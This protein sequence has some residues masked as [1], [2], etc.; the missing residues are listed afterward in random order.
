M[1]KL[2]AIFILAIIALAGVFLWRDGASGVADGK[3]AFS[4][5]AASKSQTPVKGIFRTAQ[6]NDQ[7]ST[8]PQVDESALRYFA[9]KGD[10]V[11]LQAEIKRLKA[12]YPN[13]TPPD[14]PLAPTEVRDEKLDELWGL[15]AEGRYAELRK[16]IAARKVEDTAWEAP[17]DLLQMLDQAERRQRLVNASDNKQ[18][19]MVVSLAAE[20]PELLVC[21]EVDVLWRLSE[22]F[23]QLGKTDRARDGYIYVLDNCT[24]PEERLAT[25]QKALANLPYTEAQE[26][27]AHQ[28]TGTDGKEEFASQ[29]ADIARHLLAMAAEDPEI[30]LDPRYLSAVASLAE[31][32]KLASDAEMLGWYY[33][34]RNDMKS[35]ENW[36]LQAQEK[37]D[38]PT[39]AQGLALILSSQS[40]YEQAENVMYPWRDE[41]PEAAALYFSTVTNL[42]AS[43]PPVKMPAIIPQNVMTRIAAATIAA[44]NVDS[45]QQL[46]WYARSVGQYASAMQW[47]QTALA[48]NQSNEPAAY[49][50]ALSH[51]LNDDQAALASLKNSWAAHSP[52]IAE[53]GTESAQHGNQATVRT[54][55]QKNAAR[56]A[57]PAAA[58]RAAAANSPGKSTANLRNCQKTVTGP[59][60][61]GGNAVALGWCLMERNRA[62]EAVQSF[63]S[64]LATGTAADRSE[65]AY[66]QALAYLRL[67]LVDQA[68]AASIKAPL[69]KQRQKELRIAILSDRAVAAYQ[70]G[71]FRETL[72][73]L[74]QR[75]QLAAP[76]KDLMALQAASYL[77]LNR[78]NDSR[79]VYEALAAS[80]YREGIRGLAAIREMMG[81]N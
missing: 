31:Q 22:A 15:Y 62:M 44:K 38:S 74:E 32:Q 37:T 71:N 48:W 10:T 56:P 72:L 4:D 50:L 60:P 9:S 34:R 52:R 51:L 24:V 7:P 41:T 3:F 68:A 29:A 57:Q 30:K 61:T 66:G 17:A 46:G 49:G 36:L 59:L 35:A 39:I 67:G 5:R 26:V 14:D 20:A 65:A 2:F 77:K 47:F 54:V 18:Y 28:K 58:Q 64:A 81:Q 69:S 8:A 11:R 12:L 78:L 23:A 45:A 27:L 75:A 25:I 63:E 53:V 55:P 33:L 76:R 19:D 80:G 6:A 70:G 21:G 43:D 40:Q 73:L 13:W 1:K 16:L 42:L 79:I